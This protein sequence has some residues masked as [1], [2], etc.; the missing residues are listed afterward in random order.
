MEKHQR[1]PSSQKQLPR[2]NVKQRKNGAESRPDAELIQI[3]EKSGKGRKRRLYI[4]IDSKYYSNELSL[5]TIEKTLDDMKLR[6]AYG[7]IICS[8]E[9]LITKTLSLNLQTIKNLAIVKLKTKPG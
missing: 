8:E 7:L 9:T 5:K 2:V 4:V 6:N 3:L 1:D